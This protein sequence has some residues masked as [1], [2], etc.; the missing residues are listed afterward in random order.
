MIDTQTQPTIM[1]T[2]KATGLPYSQEEEEAVLGSV[3]I[4]PDVWQDVSSLRAEDFYIHKHRYVWDALTHLHESQTQIDILALKDELERA[5]KLD[6]CGGFPFLI[7]LT[8]SAPNVY[9]AGSHANTVR[10]YA[11][12]RR[13]IA[14]ATQAINDAYDL[15]KPV[16]LENPSE[17]FALQWI[18]SVYDASEPLEFLVDGLLTKGSVNLLVGEGGSKKTWAALDL[19]VC[20]ALGKSWLDFPAEQATVLIVDEESGPRRLRRRLFETLNGH[21]VKREDVAPI[22]YT[23]LSM[24]DLRKADDVNLLHILIEQTRA[25]LVIIDALADIMPGADENA[26]KDVQPVFM[27]LRRIAETTQAAIVVIHHSNKQNGYR[28]STAIKG[29]VDLMLMVESKPEAR[30]ITFT[31]EKARDIEPKVFTAMATWQSE[32]EQFYLS[33]SELKGKQQTN[34]AQRHVLRYLLEQEAAGNVEEVLLDEI[35]DTATICAPR[36]AENAARN[37]IDSGHLTATAG[38]KGRGNKTKVALTPKGREL[39]KVAE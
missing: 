39:A 33:A 2:P 36:S 26:V 35:A 13:K 19:A 17:R 23:S 30:Y 7:Q 37:L 3:I 22:A 34:K 11:A 12:R 25:G 29:A 31:A 15:Q 8:N 20:V 5:G 21:L 4:S 24:T 9:N 1:T 32:S 14:E 16:A 18:D 27:N 38:G 10:D 6:D 28:G